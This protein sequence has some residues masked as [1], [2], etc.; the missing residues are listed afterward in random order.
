[1]LKNNPNHGPYEAKSAIVS[2]LILSDPYSLEERT[3]QLLKFKFQLDL[4]AHPWL[5]KVSGDLSFQIR[6]NTVFDDQKAHLVNETLLMIERKVKALKKVGL[7]K[8][9]QLSQIG[10]ST[11]M[12]N[13]KSKAKQ[14]KE[15]I[16]KIKALVEVKTM[17]VT[18]AIRIASTPQAFYLYKQKNDELM[19]RIRSRD[20][21]L[22]IQA[23]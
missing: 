3:V 12:R 23:D 16:E 19:Q 7:S 2:L 15:D 5:V 11:Q 22:Q 13:F 1:M 10:S 8:G 4:R 18:Q 6:D 20:L 17:N 14:T 9:S 21:M